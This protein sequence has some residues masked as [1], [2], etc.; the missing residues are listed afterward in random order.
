MKLKLL[1]TFLSVFVSFQIVFSLF[2]NVLPV[3]ASAYDGALTISNVSAV[4]GAYVE[5]PITI[6]TSSDLTDVGNI[7]FS[8]QLNKDIVTYDSFVDLNTK[9][10]GTSITTV[11]SYN[12]DNDKFV[13]V[14]VETS[15]VTLTNNEE[16]GKIKLLVKENPTAN[17]LDLTFINGESSFYKSNGVESYNINYVN[18]SLTVD[19][20]PSVLDD[21]T[22]LDYGNGK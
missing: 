5:V 17:N 18:G 2:A 11:H 12:A 10:P 8:V 9:L 6:T 14:F 13:F 19:S 22:T 4:A 3:N 1:K 21:Q 16:I 20:L 7:Q 15:G